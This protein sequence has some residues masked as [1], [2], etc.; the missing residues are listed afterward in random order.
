[1]DVVLVGEVAVEHRLAHAR[2]G[3]D[4]SDAHGGAVPVDRGDRGQDELLAPRLPVL[5]PARPAA[6]LRLV[7]GGVGCGLAP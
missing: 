4:L 7:G 2:L 6:V 5:A 3:G 1:M